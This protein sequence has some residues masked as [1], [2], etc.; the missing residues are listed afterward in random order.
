VFYVGDW[1][2]SGLHMSDE[3]LPGRLREYRVR[4]MC[5]G[6]IPV[7][8]RAVNVEPP[9]IERV[10]LTVMDVADPDLPSFSADTKR[11]DPRYRWFV[12]A[13]GQEC[14]ELDALSPIVLRERVKE[15]IVARLDSIAWERYVEA[16]RVER[17]SIEATVRTWRGLTGTPA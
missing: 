5:S 4:M 16:E 13:Y 14:W 17:E 1:D 2:P 10:A 15:A 11:G 3:D 12:E 8:Q 9:E 7:E 6:V